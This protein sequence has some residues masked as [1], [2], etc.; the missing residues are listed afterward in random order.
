METDELED[1]L[2]LLDPKVKA[3]IAKSSKDYLEG[4]TRPVQALLTEL[5]KE[6]DRESRIV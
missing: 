5:K 3:A 1:E 2:E 4:R 6:Q